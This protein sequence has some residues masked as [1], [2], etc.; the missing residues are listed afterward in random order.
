M[1]KVKTRIGIVKDCLIEDAKK[2]Q[3][4]T[5][6]TEPTS[7]NWIFNKYRADWYPKVAKIL[8]DFDVK[9]YFR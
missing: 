7:K 5:D 3:E 2:A 4:I 1:D 9:E 8:D 6:T